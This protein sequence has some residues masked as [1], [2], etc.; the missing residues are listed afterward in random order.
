MPTAYITAPRDDAQELADRL[1]TER[2]AACVNALECR[3]VYRWDDDV[4]RDD[5]A[6]LFAKTTD[7]AWD[8]LVAFVEAE[9]PYDVP[10][11]ERFDESFVE[12]GFEAWVGES[13]E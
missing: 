7:A 3:S 11:I 9:H 2:H 1:V 12:P 4:V 8:D 6:V 13:V 5:E 10:C